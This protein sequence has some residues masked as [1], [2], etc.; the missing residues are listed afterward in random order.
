MFAVASNHIG[1]DRI[2]GSLRRSRPF[3]GRN[4]DPVGP[5]VLRIQD[6][7]IILV[8]LGKD[9]P[10]F[11][12]GGRRRGAEIRRVPNVTAEPFPRP[13]M[14]LGENWYRSEKDGGEKKTGKMHRSPPAADYS[15]DE[16]SGNVNREPQEERRSVHMLLPQRV[17]ATDS[18]RSPPLPSLRRRTW[19][20]CH[21]A[22]CAASVPGARWPSAWRLCIP[23]DAPR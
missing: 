9:S 16:Q 15:P 23:V 12:V 4:H 17:I 11:P 3:A 2:A 20:P 1:T 5:E 18:R 22:R 7:R 21:S 19:S 10:R 8:S 6:L 14:I 13:G